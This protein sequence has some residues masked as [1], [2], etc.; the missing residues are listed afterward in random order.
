[1]VWDAS[2]GVI[3]TGAPDD[4]GFIV[5]AD[6][7]R[8]TSD[9]A[10]AAGIFASGHPQLGVGWHAMRWTAEEGFVDVAAALRAQG[11]DLPEFMEILEV[12]GISDDGQVITAWGYFNTVGVPGFTVIYDLE[13]DRIASQGWLIATGVDVTATFL[14]GHLVTGGVSAWL[15]EVASPGHLTVRYQSVAPSDLDGFL[16]DEAALLAALGDRPRITGWTF[17]FDGTLAPGSG[18]ALSLERPA[19]LKGAEVVAYVHD[20]VSWAPQPI[21]G[22]TVPGAGSLE[23]G[24]MPRAVAIVS[25]TAP[26]PIASGVGVAIALG[27]AATG[28]ASLRGSRSRV[29]RTRPTRHRYVE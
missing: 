11:I 8:V 18:V 29:A 26:L 9:G 10:A 23:L 24:A 28:L 27:C 6:L 13:P 21:T 4:G 1:M 14:G 16:P 19:F 12:T 3:A 15:S 25:A 17:D 2:T 20:G 22:E 7:L 5:F